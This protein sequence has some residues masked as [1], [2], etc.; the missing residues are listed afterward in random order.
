ML[1]MGAFSCQ[2]LANSETIPKQYRTISNKLTQYQKNENHKSGKLLQEIS[3]ILNIS[4]LLEKNSSSRCT[5]EAWESSRSIS[6][7]GTLLRLLLARR[8]ISKVPITNVCPF[9]TTQFQ[10]LSWFRSFF[11]SSCVYLVCRS[12]CRSFVSLYL[13]LSFCYFVISLFSYLFVSFCLSFICSVFISF[14]LSCF[15]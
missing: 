7:P 1:R 2:A 8:S 10:F 14:V 13:C 11:V 15:W 4:M 3:L 6:S 9:L 5:E 12:F